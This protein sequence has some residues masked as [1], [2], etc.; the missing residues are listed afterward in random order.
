VVDRHTVAYWRFDTPGQSVA[1][2]ATVPDR[3]GNG[4]HLTVRR[5]PGSAADALTV[6]AD[7]H[8]GAPAH[9]SLRFDGGKNPARGA[10]LQTAA[11]D[12]LNSMTFLDGYTLEVFLKLPEPFTGDHSWMGVFSW[13]GRSGDAGKQS[14]W[15]PLEPTCSLN[16]SPERFVQYVVYSQVGDVNPTH[17]SHALPVGEWQHVAVVNDG[18]RS[19]VHVNGSRIARN[20]ARAARGIA[21]LGRPFTLGGTSF[22]LRYYQT[23]HGWLGDVRITGRPL[24][25]DRFL[26]AQR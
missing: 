18:R 10:L 6:S 7:H 12:P 4:H 20:P 9:A 24:P 23:F 25:P 14:G 8:A 13:E 17:W 15:S 5:L 21:T 22:D 26:P 2:G 1:D 11:G 3:S 19:V 16:L